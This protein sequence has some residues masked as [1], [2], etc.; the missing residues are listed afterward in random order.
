MAVIKLVGGIKRGSSVCALA[1]GTVAVASAGGRIT[2]YDAS[3]T[4]I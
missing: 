3:G 2:R 1:D 4:E